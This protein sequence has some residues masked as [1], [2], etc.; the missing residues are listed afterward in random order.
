MM[1][2]IFSFHGAVQSSCHED[3]RRKTPC[4]SVFSLCISVGRSYFQ[5]KL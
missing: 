5:I 3:A 2:G 1:S 4:I